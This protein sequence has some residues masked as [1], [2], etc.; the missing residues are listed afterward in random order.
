M[1][2]LL[3]LKNDMQR[4]VELQALQDRNETL[5][6]RLLIDNI[7]L[8][9]VTRPVRPCLIREILSICMYSA[10]PWVYT[11]TVGEI[12]KQ[13]GKYVFC[14]AR[15]LL[16]DTPLIAGTMHVQHVSSYAWHVLFLTR[17]RSDELHG[18]QLAAR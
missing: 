16:C 11:P 13:F 15:A 5:F 9:G 3:G 8:L 14:L 2:M 4:G 7:D 17:P 10:A 18:V 1:S 6:Y 12:C